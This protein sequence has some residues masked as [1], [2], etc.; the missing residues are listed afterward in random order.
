MEGFLNLIFGYFGGG[1]SLTWMS[2]GKIPVV[3]RIP[4]TLPR[5]TKVSD[6]H[7]GQQQALQPEDPKV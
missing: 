1:F 7:D 6:P 2:E 3:A 5:R 4:F